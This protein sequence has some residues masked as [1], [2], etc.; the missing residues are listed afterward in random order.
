VVPLV[1]NSHGTSAELLLKGVLSELLR[2]NGRRLRFA[3]QV[4]NDQCEDKD[5]DRCDDQQAVQRPECSLQN[6]DGAKRLS[7]IHFCRHADFIFGQPCPGTDHG[8]AAIVSIAL[9]IDRRRSPTP[10]SSSAAIALDG[11]MD[12]S[13]R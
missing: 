10:P 13:P 9:N 5:G 2:F 7:D 1:N 12:E 6:D 11:R 3:P 8:H 4:G